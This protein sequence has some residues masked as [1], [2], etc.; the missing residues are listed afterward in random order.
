MRR[1]ES[2]RGKPGGSRHAGAGSNIM[3]ADEFDL[4]DA[5]SSGLDRTLAGAALLST[6][7]QL[8]ATPEPN[9][10]CRAELHHLFENGKVAR[11]PGLDD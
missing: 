11:V 8:P 6:R 4:E 10:N 3:A 1:E 2:R 7:V 5:A 9:I